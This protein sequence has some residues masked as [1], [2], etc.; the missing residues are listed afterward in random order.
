MGDNQQTS[1]ADQ[2]LVD[3][4]TKD[5]VKDVQANQTLK[6]ALETDESQKSCGEVPS[7]KLDDLAGA[8]EQGHYFF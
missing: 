2:E 8:I 3:G 1:D 6:E 7:V 4:H 5:E